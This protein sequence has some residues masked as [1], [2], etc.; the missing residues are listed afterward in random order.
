MEIYKGERPNGRNGYQI[1]ADGYKQY[2]EQ[3]PNAPEEVKASMQKDIKVLSFLSE[4]D[5]EE[6]HKL[7]NSSAFNDV[8]KGYVLKAADN[9]KYNRDKRQELINEIAYLLDTMGASE[10]EQ[11]YLDN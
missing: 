11:Y 1:T 10:S 3:N 5:K 8:L 2:L 7:F 6:K 9:L 4:C